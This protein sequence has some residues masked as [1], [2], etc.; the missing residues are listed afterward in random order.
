M[1][2]MVEVDAYIPNGLINPVLAYVLR[3]LKR[4]IVT[5][6]VCHHSPLVGLRRI[7]HVYNDSR[8]TQHSPHH[9]H[10]H[11]REQSLANA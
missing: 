2:Q 3:P 11:H 6:N 10:H 4:V 8:F 9:Y 5:R 1:E 7:H